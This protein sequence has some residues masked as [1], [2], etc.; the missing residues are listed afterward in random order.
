MSTS[1]QDRSKKSIVRPYGRHSGE[2]HYCNNSSDGRISYD[3]SAI[4]LTV[5][6]YQDMIDLGWRR[7]GT[8]LYKPQN[9]NP[10]TCCPQ[11]TI[12]LDTTLFKP[13][14]DN[15]QTKL[16][17]EN[18]I[19]HGTLKTPSSSTTINKDS[20]DE[21][22]DD[23][24]NDNSIERDEKKKKTD[25]DQQQLEQQQHSNS[26]K[27]KQ[28]HYHTELDELKSLIISLIDNELSVQQQDE[29]TTLKHNL[30]EQDILDI[31]NHLVFKVNAHKVINERG[32][33]SCGLG[34][35]NKYKSK[36]NSNQTVDQLIQKIIDS[37]PLNKSSSSSSSN[38]NRYTL[39]Y[40]DLHINIRDSNP[41]PP[42]P[43]PSTSN[44]THQNPS[45][46]S[47]T[48]T[49]T[50]TT[51]TNTSN[52]NKEEDKEKVHKFTITLHKPEFTE[53]VFKLFQKYQREVHG[54][55]KKEK[56]SF[57]RFLV[58]SPLIPVDYS[59][60]GLATR[61]GTIAIPKESGYG[62]YHQY[63]RID[64]KLVA[65]GVIDIL[66]KCLSSVYFFY[67]TDYQ[68]LNLGKY[69]ALCEIDWVKNVMTNV[70]QLKYYYMGFYIHKCQKMKYKAKFQPSDLLCSEKNEWVPLDKCIKKLDE[71]NV[72][73]MPFARDTKIEPVP[74]P[75]V[76][77]QYP[78]LVNEIPLVTNGIIF[79]LT[80]IKPQF[81]QKYRLL[82]NE[83]LDNI[84]NELATEI[85][86]SFG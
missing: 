11:Y 41:P 47:T 15:K 55:H 56:K 61:K 36:L 86:I 43:H 32:H 28:D 3:I 45:S 54:E 1:M 74:T 63:Y 23:D 38:N 75:T 64:G 50:A 73:Y 10:K 30:T 14:R 29:S 13:T 26:I 67:D 81:K 19:N 49:T 33:Y 62:S 48:T 84:G 17:F 57:T 22:E 8:Y 20:E 66:P 76:S 46:S 31:K 51:T 82:L 5:E 16:K 42:L 34:I 40:S 2:C 83:Y 60:N 53:E 69:S 79:N 68:F 21:D 70:P 52:S 9:P 39:F 35:L 6:D 27:L 65:V 80:S 78:Q 85:I 18:Y 72:S 7:S 37:Y 44:I 4:Q 58:D 77:T 71:N 25:N 12:R 59:P 24:D